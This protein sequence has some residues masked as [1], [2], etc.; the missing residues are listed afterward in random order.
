MPDPADILSFWYSEPVAKHWFRSTDAIDAE[1]RQRFESA[2]HQ[3]ASG[4]MDHW[5]DS[6]ES[7]LALIILLDQMPLNM[8]RGRPE[9][10]QTE[11]QAIECSLH[12]IEQGYDLQLPVE[13]LNFFYM[14]LMHSEKL[15]HQNLGV[16]KFEQAGLDENA[17]FARHHRE[18]V[19]RFGRF[20]HRNEILGRASTAEELAYLASDGAFRG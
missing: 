12:G 19:E 3:A 11:A 10:F 17:R 1:I 2:W 9:S 6:A 5:K 16:E 7:C 14:P 18:L 20:P 15:E 4:Q 13:R 8:F